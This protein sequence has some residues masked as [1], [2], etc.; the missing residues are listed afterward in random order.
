MFPMCSVDPDYGT[1][2]RYEEMVAAHKRY[3]QGHRDIGF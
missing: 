1:M 2:E 3:Y